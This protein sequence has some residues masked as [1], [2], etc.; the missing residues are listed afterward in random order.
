MVGKPGDLQDLE[1]G[2]SVEVLALSSEKAGV[3]EEV[4]FR[5]RLDWRTGSPDMHDDTLAI[6]EEWSTFIP[7]AGPR[8]QP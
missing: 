8:S 1:E 5:R 7:T 4:H 6:P 2:Q 3:R